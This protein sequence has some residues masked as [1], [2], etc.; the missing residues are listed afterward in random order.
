MVGSE[1]TPGFLAEDAEPTNDNFVA[2]RNHAKALEKDLREL[3]TF[4]ETAE[5]QL[6]SAAIKEA[7]FDPDPEKSPQTKALLELHKGDI[8]AEAFKQTAESYGLAPAAGDPGEGAG[9]GAPELTPEQQQ[10]I[11][12]EQRSE[13]AF[14]QA[15]PVEPQTIDAR[16]AAAE[17]KAK[18][19]GDWSEWDQL[20]VQASLARS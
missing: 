6:R 10:A 19:T 4:R 11:T 15:A 20:Q 14:S 17:T 13:Q 3:R 16:I 5:P 1:Q 12:S 9:A 8:S 7:G 18:E 2:L